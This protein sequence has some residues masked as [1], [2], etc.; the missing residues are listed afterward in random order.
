MI[1]IKPV[2]NNS[3]VG[4]ILGKLDSYFHFNMND[5]MRFAKYLVACII[6]SISIVQSSAQPTKPKKHVLIDIAHGE[7]F[8]N[9]PAK[10]SGMDPAFIERVKYMTAEITRTANSVNAD[11]GYVNN[12]ITPAEL[13]SCNLL[14]IHIP[15]ATYT[16]EEA[17][18]INDYVQNGGALF[19]VMDADYWSTLAGTNANAV[20]TPMGITF[21]GD[22]PDTE[23][24]AYTKPTEITSK[25]LKVTYHGARLISGG[26]P[27]CFNNQTGQAFGVFKKAGKGKV[28]AMG[29]GMISLYMTEWEGVKDYQCSE[30]MHEVF[31]WLLK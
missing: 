17:K 20:V 24:G 21:G 22:S 28:V 29:D 15:S 3:F 8:W 31:A 10:M 5:P 13:A 11:I 7:K 25:E 23:A 30:F 6:F 2:E 18:A 9:D 19:F 27:F 16:A 14:F 1:L 4:I 26:T 12:K